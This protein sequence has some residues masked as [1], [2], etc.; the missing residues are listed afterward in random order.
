MTYY[1]SGVIAFGGSRSGR[2]E[3]PVSVQVFNLNISAELIF[4]HSTEK[5]LRSFF[6][7]FCH[8][9]KRVIELIF[10]V[11][12]HGESVPHSLH[13]FWINI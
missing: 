7:L 5:Y 12:F 11:F 3:T 2:D 4:Y 8:R 6:V 13:L 1:R 9:E 10:T